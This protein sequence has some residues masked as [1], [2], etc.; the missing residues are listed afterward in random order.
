MFDAQP[1][2][3]FQSFGKKSDPHTPP[4]MVISERHDKLT[5]IHPDRQLN[6]CGT[7]RILR[8]LSVIKV[9]SPM[10][11]HS[12]KHQDFVLYQGFCSTKRTSP[13][14]EQPW[15]FF[16]DG[17]KVWEGGGERSFYY[18][19]YWQFVVVFVSSRLTTSSSSRGQSINQVW[20]RKYSLHKFTEC[21]S[22]LISTHLQN[23][24]EMFFLLNC[25]AN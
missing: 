5:N 23:F 22:E 9:S 10:L 1:R 14:P 18:H 20:S 16:F 4:F 8:I 7:Y 11:H 17:W 3:Q 21:W 12:T 19:Y 25:S 13:A 6:A 24:H 2:N 15:Y